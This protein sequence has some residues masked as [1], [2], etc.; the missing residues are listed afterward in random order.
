MGNIDQL[1]RVLV[2]SVRISRRL[3]S[4]P[5]IGRLLLPQDLLVFV[6]PLFLGFFL[7]LEFLLVLIF[8][9]VSFGFLL[10]L[11]GHG[12]GYLRGVAFFLF[13]AKGHFPALSDPFRQVILEKSEEIRKTGWKEISKPDVSSGNRAK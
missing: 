10:H 12:E 9:V 2:E 7:H 3:L 5:S 8:F 13:S 6:G 4:S 11:R 1:V